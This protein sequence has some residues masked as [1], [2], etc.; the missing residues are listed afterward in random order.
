MLNLIPKTADGQ[1]LRVLCLGAHSDDIEIGCGGTLLQLAASGR[2]LDIQWVVFSGNR[3]RAEEA[4]NSA[5]FWLK[6]IASKSIELHG[7]RDGFF[8]NEWA[9]IKDTFEQTK[10]AFEPDV[11]FTHY[12]DDLHQDHRIINQLT[13]NTFRNHF[14]LEYEIPKYDGDMRSPDFYIPLTEEAAKAKSA[15]LMEHFGSQRAKHWF[16]EE[17]FLGLMRIRGME[18]C[19]PSGYAEGFFSRK[20]CIAL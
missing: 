16:C 11:I 15:A 10:K 17:L 5:G 20:A 1:P 2:P 3:S 19:S 14:I 4:R 6:S 8:P 9:A 12:R 13:W 18:S 7:Y